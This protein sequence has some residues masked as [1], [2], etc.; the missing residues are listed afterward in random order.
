MWPHRLVAHAQSSIRNILVASMLEKVN[1][2]E[3]K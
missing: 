2:I 3:E 1:L